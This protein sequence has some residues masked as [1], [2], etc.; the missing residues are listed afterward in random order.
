MSD[1]TFYLIIQLSILER[2]KIGICDTKPIFLSEG[3]IMS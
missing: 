3:D 1:K 2:Y